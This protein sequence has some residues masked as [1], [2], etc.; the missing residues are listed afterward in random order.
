MRKDRPLRTGTRFGDVP[1]WTVGSLC[2]ALAEADLKPE[3]FSA[4]LEWCPEED[5]NLHD[6]AIAS[7]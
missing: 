6:L 4:D 5:S 3:R 1:D 2:R 7:T